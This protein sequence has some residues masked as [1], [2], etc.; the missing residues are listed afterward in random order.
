MTKQVDKMKRLS[1]WANTSTIW[2][3]GPHSD[4]R[5]T[6]NEPD[7]DVFRLIAEVR[8]RKTRLACG[9]LRSLRAVHASW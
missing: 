7:Y 6:T 1:G 4:D 5:H 3:H 8:R 9:F 2:I